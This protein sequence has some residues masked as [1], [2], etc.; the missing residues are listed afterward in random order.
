MTML[1]RFRAAGA[2]F[3]LVILGALAHAALQLPGVQG[4]FLGD[5]NTNLFSVAQAINQMNQAAASQ[6]VAA[7][8][9]NSQATCTVITTPLVNV[10]SSVGTGSLCLPTATAGSFVFLSNT[11]GNTVNVF[12]SN[13]P[14]VPGVQDTINATAGSTANAVVTVAHVVF[15]SPANGVWVSI[16]GAGTSG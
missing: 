4:P 16:R 13:Q 7:P 6:A 2:A 10:T 9:A 3:A 15:F 1:S 12:G 14:F 5:Q 8:N 11:T